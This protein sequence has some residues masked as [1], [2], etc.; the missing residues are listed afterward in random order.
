MSTSD[1]AAT[2]REAEYVATIQFKPEEIHTDHYHLI[3]GGSSY[4]MTHVPT[5]VTVVEEE[6]AFDQPILKRL[7]ELAWRLKLAV[8]GANAEPANIQSP[9]KR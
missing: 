8:D 1:P 7:E 5:G 6:L 9:P 4:V 2:L 3:G